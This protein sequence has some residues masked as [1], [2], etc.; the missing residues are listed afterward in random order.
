MTDINKELFR[1]IADDFFEGDVESKTLLYI[2][3]DLLD[4]VSEEYA[5]DIFESRGYFVGE[6]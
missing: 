4:N 3:R 2:V 5:V 1:M 6:E